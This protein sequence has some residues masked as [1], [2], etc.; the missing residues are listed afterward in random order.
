MMYVSA[1]KLHRADRQGY[2][3]I[4]SSDSAE[5]SERER[6]SKGRIGKMARKRFESM[7]RSMSGKRVEI[8]R[9]MEFA[10]TRAEAADE[11]SALLLV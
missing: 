2:A 4:Y 3:S 5:D 6:T 9:A 7:L 1:H 11:A 10:L 8:A